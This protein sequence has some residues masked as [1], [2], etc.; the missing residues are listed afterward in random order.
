MQNHSQTNQVRTA[1][2][3]LGNICIS[4]GSNSSSF[5]FGYDIKSL[6]ESFGV[7]CSSIP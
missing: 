6:S 5:G 1:S 3:E 7:A 4:G 2:D